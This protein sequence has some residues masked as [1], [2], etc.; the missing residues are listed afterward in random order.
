MLFHLILLRYAI[1]KQ[2]P[3][4]QKILKKRLFRWLRFVEE[5]L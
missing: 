1:E 5:T 2:I 4:S 3:Y